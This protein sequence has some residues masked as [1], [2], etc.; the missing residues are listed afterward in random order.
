M[1]WESGGATRGWAPTPD[2]GA[3]SLL[4]CGLSIAL[5]HFIRADECQD[6]HVENETPSANQPFAFNCTY[7]WLTPGK[8]RVTWYKYPSKIPVSKNIQSRI[9]QDQNWILFLPLTQGDSGIYQCVI[10]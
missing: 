2:M 6:I 4:L 10:K 9:Y 8:A 3:V 1:G 5:P 7:P